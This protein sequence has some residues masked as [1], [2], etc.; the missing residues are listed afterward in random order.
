MLAACCVLGTAGACD[1]EAGAHAE[2]PPAHA[3]TR[4]RPLPLAPPVEP[5]TPAQAAATSRGIDDAPDDDSR[6]RGRPIPT[7]D[8][9]LKDVDIANVC[10]LLADV[11]KVNIV[12]ADDVHGSVTMRLRQVPWDRALEV[13]L[14]TKGLRAERRGDIL[15]VR[16]PAR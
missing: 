3:A 2:A 6:A 1:A 13:I 11:A 9:D 16:G 15:L 10:R 7:V 4:P 14:A 8:L 5:A 12:V